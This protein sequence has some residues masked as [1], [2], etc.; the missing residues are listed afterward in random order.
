MPYLTEQQKQINRVLTYIEHNLDQKLGLEELAQVSTYSAYHFQRLFKELAGES[1]AQYVKRLRLEQAAHYLIYEGQ[2]NVTDI[3]M[4]C[5]FSSL[6]YFTTA[7]TNHFTYSPKAWREGAYLNRFPR[8]YINRK[9][10]K[11]VSKMEKEEKPLYPYNEFRWIDLTKVKTIFLPKVKAVFNQSTGPYTVGVE[12]RLE[13]LYRWCEARDLIEENTLVMG[14]PKNNPYI[15]PPEKC[16]YDCCISIH[17]G[18][19]A[20][21]FDQMTSDFKGGKHV[22]FVFEQPVSFNERGKLIECYSELYSYWLP[23]SGYRYLGNPVEIIRIEKMNGSMEL[24]CSIKAIALAIE[25]K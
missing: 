24:I 4:L 6:S 13:E 11:Q 12:D 9:K 23:R 22:I 8:E 25:P 7:F 10:S 16:R 15:T 3:A 19:S 14:I 2:M 20:E 1:P 18:I 17:D 21:A 5:G